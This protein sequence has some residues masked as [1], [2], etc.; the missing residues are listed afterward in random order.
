MAKDTMSSLLECHADMTW[1]QR[2][3]KRMANNVDKRKRLPY[4]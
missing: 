3:M 4:E 1:F 2:T